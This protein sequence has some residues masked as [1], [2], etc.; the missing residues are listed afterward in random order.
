VKA[1][2]RS[3]AVPSSDSESTASKATD[4]SSGAGQRVADLAE[5]R[6]SLFTRQRPQIA[7]LEYDETGDHDEATRQ[8][9]NAA[10]IDLRDPDLND[11]RYKVEQARERALKALRDLLVFVRQDT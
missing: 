7:P 8:A 3:V 5:Q 10:A 9:N 11:Q 6:G 1:L 2:L 4:A